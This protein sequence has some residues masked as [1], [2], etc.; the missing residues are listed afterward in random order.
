MKSQ[1]II[2]G[3]FLGWLWLIATS[4]TVTRQSQLCKL[5]I[6]Y[7]HS[8]TSTRRKQMKASEESSRKNIW[9]I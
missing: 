7:V 8:C 1:C 3:L 9:N 4:E 6:T 5:A 2:Y